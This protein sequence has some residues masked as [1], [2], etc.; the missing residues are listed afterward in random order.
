MCC[1][2]FTWGV[3]PTKKLVSRARTPAMPVS[4]NGTYWHQRAWASPAVGA[5]FVF[6]ITQG[7]FQRAGIAGNAGNGSLRFFPALPA[8]TSVA[9]NYQRCQQLPAL[10][11][12]TS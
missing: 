9:S 11:A 5:R 6:G 7:K 12:I 2:T 1:A 8:I 10:P 3:A 4:L